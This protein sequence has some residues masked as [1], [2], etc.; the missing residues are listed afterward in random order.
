MRDNNDCAVDTEDLVDNNEE[1]PSIN[2]RPKR[3]SAV[4]GVKRLEMLFDEKN[5]Q[6]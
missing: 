5:T 1:E 2:K 6:V 3:S 4:H